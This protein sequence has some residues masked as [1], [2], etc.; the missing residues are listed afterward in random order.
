MSLVHPYT[1]AVSAYRPLNKLIPAHWQSSTVMVRD[2]ATIHYTRTGGDKPP[3]LLIHG[4]QIN[5]LTWARTAIALEHDY[6]VIMPDARGHGK[7]SAMVDQLQRDQMAN[8]IVD[9]I[10]GLD[11]GDDLCVI[12]HSMGADI[13]GRL[14]TK[15]DLKGLILVDPALKN[16]VKSFQL[17]LSE[18]PAWL[19]PIINTMKSLKSLPHQERMIA[20]LKLIQP[21]APLWDEIDYVTFI[22]ANAEFDTDS[23][24]QFMSMDYLIE[25]PD[26][27]AKIACPTLL[28]TAKQMSMSPEEFQNAVKGYIDHLPNA[29]HIHWE[30]SQHFMFFDQFEKFI[31]LV[32]QTITT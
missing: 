28:F 15:I 10:D 12:G 27:I 13:A 4:F 30:D 31:D 29:T 25:Q 26:V 2:G 22:E 9:L 20:G 1:E 5:G 11:I 23:Y 6:D 19:V 8:D 21:T 24:M 16:F 18:P 17:D 32:R 3:L 7:S 14:A